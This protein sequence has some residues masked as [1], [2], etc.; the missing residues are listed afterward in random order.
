MYLA[1]SGYSD[2]AIFLPDALSFKLKMREFNVLKMIEM[3][4]P[5]RISR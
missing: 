4:A 5:S 1:D 2:D 3:H